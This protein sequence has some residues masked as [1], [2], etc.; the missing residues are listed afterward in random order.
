M[1][2]SIIAAV[3]QKGGIGLKNQI[4]WHLPGDL[5][6][7]KKITLGHHLILGRK[8]YQS[9]GNPLPG[10]T[11]IVLSSNPDFSLQGSLTASSL[12]EALELARSREEKEVFVIGGGEIYRQALPLADR[13]YLTRVHASQQADT[14]FPD[15]NQEDWEMICSQEVPADK[16]NPY[17]STFQYLVRKKSSI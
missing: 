2:L 15:W 8:T 1:I 9:I 4:P 12:L 6:R 11:M 16:D 14:W 10:R 7:F 13:M 17:R 5:I 3:D